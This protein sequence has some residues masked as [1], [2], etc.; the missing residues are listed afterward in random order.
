MPG[1]VYKKGKQD[2][3]KASIIETKSTRER[4]AKEAKAHLTSV[5]IP[6]W[7]Q[8]SDEE[9]GG[10]YGYMDHELRIDKKAVKGC[11]LNSRILWFFS[12]AYLLFQD[13]MLLEDAKHAFCFLKKAF[14][15]ADEGGVYWSV[16]YEGKPQEDMKHTYNQAFAIYALSSFYAASGEKEALTMALELFETVESKCTDAFGYREAFNRSFAETDNDKL[17]EN[18]ILAEKTMNT[19]LHI[20]E[21]Y[22][23]LYRISGDARVKD[24]I[25]WIMDV[26]AGKVYNAQKHRQ[27][28]FFDREMNSLLDLH[29]LGHDIET[30]WLIDRGT[31]VLGEKEYVEKMSPI[32]QDLTAEVYRHLNI[33]GA[34]ASETE[35]DLPS[36]GYVWWVQAETVV[37]FLNGYEKNPVKEEYLETASNAWKFIL[38]HIWDRRA[39]GE[40]HSEIDGEYRSINKPEVDPWKCPYHNGRMCI[41]MINRAK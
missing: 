40:W 9:H 23:E 38:D 5:I 12:N 41:E 28:V 11:I 6:F 37:G 25:Q 20:F 1:Q 7:H 21:A 3:M 26:F 8:L 39:G 27:E 31:E 34:L 14:W 13:E 19:L 17:S 32:T 24:R 10:Y 29:S 33:E 30:A 4:I 22:T 16:T 2:K 15:D 36:A 35:N 18:G